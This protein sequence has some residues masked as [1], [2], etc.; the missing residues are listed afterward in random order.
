MGF[1]NFYCQIRWKKE[2][3]D[4]VIRRSNYSKWTSRNLD[5]QRETCREEI[6]LQASG[7]GVRSKGFD[8]RSDV[9]EGMG[10]LCH[11]EKS[12]NA[13]KGYRCVQVEGKNQL[14]FIGQGRQVYGET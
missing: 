3:C 1:T 8:A 5:R 14:R 6:K 2:V 10:K 7:E 9:N 11:T 12:H 13:D 4:P